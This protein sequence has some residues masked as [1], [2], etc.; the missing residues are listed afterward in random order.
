MILP[1]V[2][3]LIHAVNKDSPRNKHIKLWWDNCLSG[4]IPVY[5]PWVVILGFVRISTNPRIFSSPLSLS[6]AADYINS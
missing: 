6:E 3:I 5:L 1:D 4:L 2:N